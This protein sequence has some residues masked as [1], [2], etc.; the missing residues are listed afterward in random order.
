MDLVHGSWP[1]IRGQKI[2]FLR[3]D[4]SRRINLLW[5][6]VFFPTFKFFGIENF[7]IWQAMTWI[8]MSWPMTSY[9]TTVPR[10][11]CHS[12][13]GQ[14]TICTITNQRNHSVPTD[15]RCLRFAPTVYPVILPL[16][17]MKTIPW[18]PNG[19][20]PGYINRKIHVLGVQTAWSPTV[21]GATNPRYGDR[22]KIS[23]P[24]RQFSQRP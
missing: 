1:R 9:F 18:W 8:A 4:A 22:E 21:V 11:M 19:H 23:A 20:M 2:F 10:V 24:N 6:K 16:F 12:T 13:H 5:K 14:N 17:N 15:L 3:I 7:A